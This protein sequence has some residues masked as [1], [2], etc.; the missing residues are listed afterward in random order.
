MPFGKVPVL[1]V[2]GKQL[3][4]STAISRYLGRQAKLAGKDDWEALQIDIA[5]DTIHDLRAGTF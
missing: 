2:D 1:E 5:V 4:Q 3:H